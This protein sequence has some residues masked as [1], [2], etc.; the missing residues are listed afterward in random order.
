MDRHRKQELLTTYRDGLLND[1]LPFWLKHAV[2]REY[3]GFITS[4]NRDG[5]II[6]QILERQMLNS[7]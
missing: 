6:D 7:Q 1:T 5:Q 4:L 2:D 3:G